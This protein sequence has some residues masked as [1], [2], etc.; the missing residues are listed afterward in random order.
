MRS[1]STIS[2]LLALTTG[3]FAAP[4][5]SKYDGGEFTDPVTKTRP[6]TAVSP[7]SYYPVSERDLSGRQGTIIAFTDS[8][9]FLSLSHHQNSF[10]ISD[11]NEADIVSI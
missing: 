2:T 6:T 9:F 8:P 11:C 4:F 5:N 1:L 7:F 3:A 10:G